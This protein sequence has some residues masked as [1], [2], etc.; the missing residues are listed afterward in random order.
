[1][2]FIANKLPIRLIIALSCTLG[3]TS[4]PVYAKDDSTRK[5][6]KSMELGA[7]SF[8]VR[9]NDG[10][11]VNL[12]DYKGRVTLIVNTASLC[13]Y[14]PQ[15][16]DLQEIHERYRTRGFS[17]LAF[18]SN[19]F[20]AQEPGTDV[21]IREFCRATYDI[22]FP[23]FTKSRVV[24]NGKGELFAFLTENSPKKGEIQWNFEKFLIDQD[25]KVVSRF[26]SAVRPNDI[27]VTGKIEELLAREE[28]L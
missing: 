25:G 28:D 4:S 13:G 11:D 7:Y 14:T 18:P 9:D 16:A 27:S 6:E 10:R 1:M 2:I 24:G 23:L 26:K 20:G 22:Q 17:V 3:L 12:G 15:Y 8:T 19:D 21:E 5:I